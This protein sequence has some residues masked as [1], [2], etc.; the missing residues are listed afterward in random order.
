MLIGEIHTS[1]AP[2]L[3][4][5]LSTRKLTPEFL[6]QKIHC[7][8]ALRDERFGNAHIKNKNNCPALDIELETP[9]VV[10]GAGVV[11]ADAADC[12]ENE[13]SDICRSNLFVGLPM[14]LWQRQRSSGNCSRYV[15]NNHAS[16]TSITPTPDADDEEVVMSVVF[17]PGHHSWDYSWKGGR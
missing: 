7:S 14:K 13:D 17:N 6:S 15:A 9:L 4:S 16:N 12:V 1:E 10:D 11:D 8:A 5:K 2:S 3:F